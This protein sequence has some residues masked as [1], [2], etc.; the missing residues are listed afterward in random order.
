MQ[1]TLKPINEQVVVVF[2]ASSGIGR[3]TALDFASRGASV[4]VASRSKSGLDSLVEEIE[5]D[6]GRAYAITADAAN[7]AEV[8]AVA[9]AASERFGGIDTWAHVAGTMILAPFEETT[10]DEFKRLIEVNL[11]GQIY[12]AKVA[13]PYLR[14]RGQGALIHVSSVEAYRA[15]PLQSAYGASKHGMS[16]FIESLRVELERDEVEI[17]VTEIMPAVINTPIWDKGRNKLGYKSHPP[18]PPIYHP[19]IVS[20]TILYAAENSVRRL[21]AGGGAVGVTWLERFS[22]FLTDKVT[23]LV[24]FDQTTDEPLPPD[25]PDGLFEPVPELDTIEGRFSDEQFTSDPY[26]WAKTNPNKVNLILAGGL[27]GG[28]LA[29]G[30]FRRKE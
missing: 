7:Y 25:A 22:P 1:I 17:S 30:I 2:G 26:V 16:G 9:H 29:Y 27:I 15:L 20:D 6:G 21:V 12:G 11:L 18:V 3:Q 5:Q 13:L 10:P 24:G 23:Q 14:K 28:L 4:V 19:Q 8:E